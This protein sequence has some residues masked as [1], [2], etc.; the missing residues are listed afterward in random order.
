MK[1]LLTN[2]DGFGAAGLE[3]LAAKLCGEHEVWIVAPDKN[4][5]G[6]SSCIT[7]DEPLRIKN[8]RERA[9]SC[10]GTPTDCVIAALRSGLLGSAPD[11]VLSGINAGANLGT[12]IVYSGTA[13]AARQA[14]FYGVPGVALS[15]RFDEDIWSGNAEPNY[16]A[17][18]DFAAKNLAAL[19]SLSRVAGRDGAP[20]GD[21][22]FVNVN[23]P[24][25]KRGEHYKGV[26]FSSE[27]CIREYRDSVHLVDGPDGDTYGFFLGEDLISHGGKQSDFAICAEGC[28]AVS[29]VYAEPRALE[30]VDDISFSL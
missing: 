23:A 17:L 6:V 10:S 16:D 29:R 2:D 27:L 24:S 15:L 18:A 28:V 3:T 14:V 11:V 12:D 8:L 7:M 30:T 25:I 19:A 9:Y 13:A 4:R 21:S 22:V 1:L 5:S 20:F 26:K